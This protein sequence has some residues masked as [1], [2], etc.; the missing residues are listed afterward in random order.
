V[1]GGEVVSEYVKLERYIGRRGDWFCST[2]EDR[3]ILYPCIH[4]ALQLGNIYF[5]SYW[6]GKTKLDKKHQTFIDALKSGE[7]AVLTA[8]AEDSD[9]KP[10]RVGYVGRFRIANVRLDDA[11]LHLEL[12]EQVAR[13]VNPLSVNGRKARRGRGSY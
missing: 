2:D 12:V 1:G 4:Q 7:D 10:H 9:G 3:T 6:A 8:D 5:D 11:G 13:A